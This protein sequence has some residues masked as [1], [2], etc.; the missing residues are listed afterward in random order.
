M[1]HDVGRSV[2]SH[3]AFVS[4]R[5]AAGAVDWLCRPRCAYLRVST[6][7]ELM[8]RAVDEGQLAIFF[9]VTVEPR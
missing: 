1:L 5:E 4:L 9:K 3:A 8:Q 7:D 2:L 6:A